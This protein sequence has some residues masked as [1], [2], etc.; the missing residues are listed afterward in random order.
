VKKAI[1]FTAGRTGSRLIKANLTA[2][3]KIEAVS[4]HNPMFP[5]GESDICIVSK[6]KNGFIAALSMVVASKINK[7][8]FYPSDNVILDTI[9]FIVNATD[10]SNHCFF[11]KAFYKLIEKRNIPNPI[12]I[13]YEDMVADRFYLFNKLNLNYPMKDFLQKSPYNVLELV[14]NWEELENLFNTEMLVEISDL[15]MENFENSVAM[16]LDDIKINYN[17]NRFNG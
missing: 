14:P 16:D 2:V 8:H 5:V 4:M 13:F 6:R 9:P 12:E 11:Q 1:I 17:G 15:E 3:L 10:I 7:F